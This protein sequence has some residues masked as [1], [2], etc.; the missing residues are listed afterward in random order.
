MEFDSRVTYTVIEPMVSLR[1]VAT[2]IEADEGI[3]LLVDVID[4]DSVDE[5]LFL[6]F[7]TEILKGTT[8]ELTV[9]GYV[10]GTRAQLS[11]STGE[12]VFSGYHALNPVIPA[13]V[14]AWIRDSL[15]PRTISRLSRLEQLPQLGV[16]VQFTPSIAQTL[17]IRLTA[18]LY[19]RLVL[20][21]PLS[22]VAEEIV[23]AGGAMLEESAQE[24]TDEFEGWIRDDSRE[25][26]CIEDHDLAVALAC[27]VWGHENVSAVSKLGRGAR[28]TAALEEIEAF[29][30]VDAAA[31]EE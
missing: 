5:T 11:G 28:F 6:F 10:A 1:Q 8:T 29:E 13:N 30:R 14:R 4:K 17:P 26:W 7:P 21:R 22:E 9:I 24:D 15:E 19:E 23:Q 27:L 2:A 12:L 31:R 25:H 20:A 18:G 16:S 3:E